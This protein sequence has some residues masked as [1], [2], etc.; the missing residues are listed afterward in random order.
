M[1]A[2]VLSLDGDE[3]MGVVIDNASVLFFLSQCAL[4]N[5]VITVPR[6]TILVD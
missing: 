6:K 2:V 1:F 5:R 4:Y 3:I